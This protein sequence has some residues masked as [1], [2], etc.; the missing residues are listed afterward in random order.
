MDLIENESSGLFCPCTADV[1]VRGRALQDRE[2]T[3]E[4]VSGDEVDQV[5]SELVVAVIVVAVDGRLF[6][7][8]VHP[9]DLPIGPWVMGLGQ[10]MLD[11][12]G[13]ADLIKSVDPV[14]SGPAI[15]VFWQDSELNTV[16]GQHR[17]QPVWH[18]RDQGL[19]ETP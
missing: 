9:F 8:A 3:G 18:C 15:A 11:A 10:A 7:R 13:S 4:I 6:D 5:G 14:S 12:L 19:Q 16:I 1:F 17:M 2:T